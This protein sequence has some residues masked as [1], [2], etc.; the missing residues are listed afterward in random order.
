MRLFTHN[1]LRCNMKKCSGGYQ[2]K[3][4]AKKIQT[5]TIENSTDGSGVEYSR[6][7]ML[8]FLKKV[9][10]DALSSA[11]TDLGLGGLTEIMSKDGSLDFE[12]LVKGGSDNSEGISDETFK[13]LHEILFGVSIIEGTFICGSCGATYPIM[14]GIADMVIDD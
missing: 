14:N 3:I 10:V 11:T 9:D 5:P 8:R 2:L 4:N 12:T 1:L 6:E 7:L 13:K